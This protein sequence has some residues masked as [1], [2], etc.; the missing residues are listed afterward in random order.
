[1]TLDELIEVRIALKAKIDKHNKDL[2]DL[3]IELDANDTALFAVLDTAGINR[4]ANSNASVSINEDIAP[5]V[6]DWDQL[7]QQIIDTKDFSLLQRRVSATA[8]REILK[9]G[10]AVSGVKPRTV[11]RINFR[12]L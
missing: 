11:R 5:E 4:A 1:M 12:S 8:Y 7:Y 2:K 10:S 3:K 9:Q 6:E